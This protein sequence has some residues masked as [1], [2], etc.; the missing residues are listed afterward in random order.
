MTSFVPSVGRV[1]LL[2]IASL[3]RVAPEFGTITNTVYDCQYDLTQVQCPACRG[4][5]TMNEAFYNPKNAACISSTEGC[6]KS[7]DGYEYFRKASL[8]NYGVGDTVQYFYPGASGEIVRYVLANAQ[9]PNIEY[10]P[11]PGKCVL[12]TDFQVD[13]AR[14]KILPPPPPNPPVPPSPPPLPSTPPCPPPSP[15]PPTARS[16]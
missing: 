14:C 12:S 3:T 9:I 6:C 10:I 1:L 4:I 2:L 13:L 7:D 16:R 5:A 15:P 11:N 8:A